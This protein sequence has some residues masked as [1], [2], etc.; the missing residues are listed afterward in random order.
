MFNHQAARPPRSLRILKQHPDAYQKPETLPPTLLLGDLLF[1]APR[2]LGERAAYFGLSCATCHPGGAATT[3]IFVGPESDRP[4]NV[5]LLSNYFT[6]FADDGIY[7]PRNVP[8]LR[9]IRF[10][11]PY[12]RDGSKA[13]LASVI[14]G[15]VERE[16]HQPL[17]QEWLDALELYVSEIDFLPNAQIDS[18]GRLTAKASEA[19]K[20]GEAV[21]TAPRT[22][23]GGRSCA[24]CHVP[25]SY[26]TDHRQH[27][28]R[29]GV[30][31]GTSTA[32]EAFA[33]PSLINAIET[34]PY[35][36]GSSAGSV[37]PYD[38]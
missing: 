12:E 21:F 11:G 24:T 6:P 5:D 1:H 4:G 16:F 8:S 34:P 20:R 7:A 15:V 19:A 23:W 9:G 29:H 3:D 14:S 31:E 36:F 17:R 33:T 22:A 25:A 35:F 30:G 13:T 27:A 37:G 2:L 10:T 28:F 26:F 32:A 38:W 18:L